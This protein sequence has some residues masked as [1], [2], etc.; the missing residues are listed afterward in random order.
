MH[1][2]FQ[3]VNFSRAKFFNPLPKSCK[4]L[5][6]SILRSKL[7]VGA[8][9]IKY[10]HLV[11]SLQYYPLFVFKYESYPNS[12]WARIKSWIWFSMQEKKAFNILPRLGKSSHPP[13]SMSWWSGNPTAASLDFSVSC[14]YLSPPIHSLSGIPED[15]NYWGC[16]GCCS[17]NQFGSGF[18]SWPICFQLS[19]GS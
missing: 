4:I 11:C 14:P 6:T 10:H 3:W 18:P 5:T 8:P 2:F 1:I 19:L 7:K 13:D 12:Q 15:S 16:F 9:N 17:S